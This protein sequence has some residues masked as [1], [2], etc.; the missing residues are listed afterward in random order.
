MRNLILATGMLMLTFGCTS[1]NRN[2]D[3]TREIVTVIPCE[4]PPFIL[5]DPVLNAELAADIAEYVMAKNGFD[6]CDRKSRIS[7]CE[8]IYTVAFLPEG[9]QP[10]STYIIDI[11][12]DT[13]RVLSFRVLHMELVANKQ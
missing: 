4:S 7:F 11:D 8:G 3:G 12:A 6:C 10:H 1:V 2:V 9:G 5:G 13:S